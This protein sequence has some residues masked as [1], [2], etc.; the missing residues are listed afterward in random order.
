[1]KIFG[2]ETASTH[3]YHPTITR[4]SCLA[5]LTVICLYSGTTVCSGFLVGNDLPQL[6]LAQNL[7]NIS[8]SD[9]WQLLGPF[10]CGTRG[11]CRFNAALAEGQPQ[12]S[13]KIGADLTAI[14]GGYLGCRSL[15][16][17]WWF[18]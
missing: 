6:L 5:T 13:G 12:T 7:A 10:H 15:G 8:F 3:K 4:R 11:S 1:M 9:E 14:P 18:S 16:I 17:L 2:A